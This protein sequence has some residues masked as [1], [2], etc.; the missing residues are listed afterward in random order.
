[1]KREFLVWLAVLCA[2]WTAAAGAPVAPGKAVLLRERPLGGPAEA[3]RGEGGD[4]ETV[5]VS[6]E[7]VTVDVP[8]GTVRLLPQYV[9]DVP[10]GAESLLVELSADDPAED[11]DVALSY[12]V[13]VEIDGSGAYGDIV[14]ESPLGKEEASLWSPWLQA[15]R[16]YVGVDSWSDKGSRCTLRVTLNAAFVDMASGVEADVFVPEDKTD[17][18]DPY[19]LPDAHQYRFRVPEGTRSVYFRFESDDLSNGTVI[20]ARYME[21]CNYTEWGPILTDKEFAFAGGFQEACLTGTD[22]LPGEDLYFWVCNK[23]GMIGKW[24][25][26]KILV[27]ADGC[28]APLAPGGAVEDVARATRHSREVLL[29]A[30]QFLVSLRDPLAELELNLSATGLPANLD[31]F[32]RKGAPVELDDEKVLADFQAV[33]TGTEPEALRIACGDLSAGDYYV[34]VSNPNQ[35]PIAYS[36]SARAGAPCP[37]GGVK[38]RRGDIDENTQV[39]LTDAVALLLHL[40]LG[41]KPPGCLDAADADD[42]GAL[43]ITDA[44]YLLAGL[45]LGSPAPPA[46]TEGCGTDPTDDALGCASYA[47][48]P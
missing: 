21:P 1:M 44:I 36:L 38:F 4:G 19:F 14:S 42:D 39:N 31:L 28:F 7:D 13:P 32:V 30:R 23:G 25:S 41:G 43:K 47:A 34:A 3:P 11:I 45:F 2:S 12:G 8:P 9:I 6:G 22:V 18:W 20:G 16:Y 10:E 35:E 33:A 5:L 29:G 17:S 48:C 24:L 46:P 37:G 15:G 26:G 27:V 40:F